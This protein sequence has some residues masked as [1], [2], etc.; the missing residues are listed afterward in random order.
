MG[1]RF[2]LKSLRRRLWRLAKL[3]E[4]RKLAAA[5]DYSEG[6]SRTVRDTLKATAKRRAWHA[7]AM[8]L[9]FHLWCCD[10]L[11]FFSTEFARAL[12]FRSTVFQRVQNSHTH[13][14]ILKIPQ[15]PHK[16][17]AQAKLK[18]NLDAARSTG[19][20]FTSDFDTTFK[21]FVDSFVQVRGSSGL[22]RCR[23]KSGES[24]Q[25]SRHCP[26]S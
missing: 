15:G 8:F 17:D 7:K 26:L 11:C 1:L 2:W 21:G 19:S 12:V 18:E 24:P 9:P 25:A 20:S 14:T 5:P 22:V 16:P 6:Q 3:V 23:P 10:H 4:G 13:L